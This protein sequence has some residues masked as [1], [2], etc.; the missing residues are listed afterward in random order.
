MSQPN[1]RVVCPPQ[2]YA[3]TA[4]SG[5]QEHD[6]FETAAAQCSGWIPDRDSVER[7]RKSSSSVGCESSAETV[8]GGLSIAEQVIQSALRKRREEVAI[9]ELARA[10]G[11]DMRAP[12]TE[13]LG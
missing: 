5:S 9:G 7:P 6:P 3:T 4:R 8:G 13:A 11:V 12:I 2:A 10:E 1:T